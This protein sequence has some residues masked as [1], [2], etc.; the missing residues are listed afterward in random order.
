MN[1]EKK[2]EVT[3]E[4]YEQL[5][6]DLQRLKNQFAANELAMSY[7]FQNAAGD[8]AHDNGEFESLQA[9]EKMLAGQIDRLVAR[10]QSAHIIEVP[11]L[12]VDQVNVNDIVV[13]R[14]Q[15]DMDD[16]EEDTYTLVGGDGSSIS[17]QISINSPIGKAIF[18]RYIGE[19]VSY[20]VN[21][22]ECQVKILEKKSSI[23]R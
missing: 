10:I 18:Q 16:I 5:L 7:S 23:K 15:Y 13:L 22:N 4:G 19:T 9:T 14:M 20:E 1:N 17:N 2:F 11:E 21:G 3:K 12:D 6:R 8:G